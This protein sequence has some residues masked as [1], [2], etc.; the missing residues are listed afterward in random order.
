[1]NPSTVPPRP[2]AT[3]PLG[4]NS[5]IA[6][7]V[8]VAVVFCVYLAVMTNGV[9]A[10]AT[11]WAMYV[12]HARNILH[13]RPYA[14]TPYVYQPE[15]ALE[16][17]RTYPSGFAL[18]LVPFYAAFGLNV[19]IYKIVVDA[20]LA[21]SLWPI[22]IISRRFLSPLSALLIVIA[23]GFGWEYVLV[24]NELGSD[25]LYQFL[26]FAS[27]VFALWIYDRGK[28]VTQGWLWGVLVGLALAAAY[29]TRPIGIAL[30]LAVAIADVVRRRRIRAFT[31]ALLATFLMVVLLNNA[32]F[33]KDSA[34]N[35][36]FIFSPRLIAS[37]AVT[38]LG[39]LSH[40]FANPLSNSLRHLLWAP[41]VLLAVAGIWSSVRRNGLTLVE[42]YCAIVMGVLCVYWL[43]NTR[44]LLPLLPIYLV[45]VL[46]GAE[47]VLE[48]IPQRYRLGL[49]WAGAAALLVA[50]AINLARIGSINQDSL[51][52]T[53]AFDQLCQQI[54]ARTGAH[55]YVL[56]WNPRVLALYTGR[57]SSPYPPA[58]PPRVQ[59]FMDRV[60]PNY[61]V[62]DKDWEEDRKYLAPVI[63]SQPERYRT[64]FE[65]AQFKLSEVMGA[66]NRHS[67]PP[68]PIP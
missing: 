45:Y 26:S 27:I 12:M 47:V 33:H 30:V 43:P 10:Q 17:P 15:T 37:H 35:D 6:L 52:A 4:L 29:L 8:V 40:V 5:G 13:G 31:I 58:G 51:I 66:P 42:I 39:Y 41:S 62:L 22:Y 36:E 50:P 61:I 28:D 49:R 1:M 68:A 38:Y 48:R 64:I 9:P 18:M 32:A 24:Q 11:D 53:P 67:D 46:I 16:G 54:G 34:Y 23:T 63:D 2:P 21:L 57:P 19:R 14:E 20:T 55:D 7:A 3:A 65:N 60:Q 25:S 59:R 56:F 44:Y